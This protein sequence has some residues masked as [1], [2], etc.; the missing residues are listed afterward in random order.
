MT[1]YQWEQNGS[2]DEAMR[3]L[4]RGH[5][6]LGKAKVRHF[7]EYANGDQVALRRFRLAAVAVVRRVHPLLK[8]ET[9]KLLAVAEDIADDWDERH[10][11]AARDT[12]WEARLWQ[13]EGPAPVIP[14]IGRT[15]EENWK[16]HA[17]AGAT[18]AVFGAM[19]RNPVEGLKRAARNGGKAYAAWQLWQDALRR[20]KG[21]NET[22]ERL[23][24]AEQTAMERFHKDIFKESVLHVVR[25]VFPNPAG[26][27]L[28]MQDAFRRLR[29][30]G[31][32][33]VNIADDAERDHLSPKWGTYEAVDAAPH[34]RRRPGRLRRPEPGPGDPPPARRRQGP[35]RPRL[36]GR[37]SRPGEVSQ[38]CRMTSVRGVP[39]SG[40]GGVPSSCRTTSTT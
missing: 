25:D 27:D 9:A 4:T 18:N 39:A 7:R 31:S 24:L 14:L 17:E 21:P 3:W 10:R 40:S 11:T 37:R 20:S 28:A 35:A 13:S 2:F 8:P 34:P 30:A 22:R 36:L 15:V 23:T 6:D 29:A 12:E 32:P 33:A 38:P 26:P 5:A 19:Y 1:D 16:N